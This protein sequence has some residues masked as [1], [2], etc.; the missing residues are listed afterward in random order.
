MATQTPQISFIPEK[1]DLAIYA[2]DAMAVR[3][4]A[5]DRSTREPL[6][7]SGI[8]EAQIRLRRDSADALESFQIDNSEA[9]DGVLL[10]SLTSVQTILLGDRFSGVWDVQWTKATEG[11]EPLTLAQGRV[12]SQLNVTRD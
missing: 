4:V 2:G 11:A 6:D 8:H 5:R 3:I 1:V 7:I 9:A 10:L 12:T